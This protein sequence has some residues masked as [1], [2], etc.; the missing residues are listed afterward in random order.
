M[1]AKCL[2]CGA[3][4]LARRSTAKFCSDRCR[5]GAHRREPRPMASAW[6][7]KAAYALARDVFAPCGVEVDAGGF[8]VAFGFPVRGT[9]KTYVGG[10]TLAGAN[11]II[12][13][14][15]PDPA[16]VLEILT[17]EVVHVV[18]GLA[19]G[20]GSEFQRIAAAVGLL[21]PWRATRAGPTLVEKLRAIVMHIGPMPTSMPR[22]VGTDRVYVSDGKGGLVLNRQLEIPWVP[23]RRTK[24]P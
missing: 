17:H 24:S 16:L 15:N 6:L 18:V 14:P 8:D 21:P 7:R 5:V 22:V 19:A 20:H 23:P 1:N 3:A 10:A 4:F 13:T 9:G 11:S 12:V 2:H